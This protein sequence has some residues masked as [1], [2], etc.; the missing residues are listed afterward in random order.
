MLDTRGRRGLLAEKGRLCCGH[1]GRLANAPHT[2]MHPGF[3][4]SLLATPKLSACWEALLEFDS[5]QAVIG[6]R[7]PNARGGAVAEQTRAEQGGH[8][9]AGQG[10]LEMQAQTLIQ[11]V[12]ADE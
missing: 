9:G 3:P 8:K 12:G 6:C 4:P 10:S 5:E 1:I 11:S 7:K 2:R